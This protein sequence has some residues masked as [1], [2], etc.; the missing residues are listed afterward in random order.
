MHAC[1][2]R[3]GPGRRPR[4]GATPAG[5]ELA[6]EPRPP[7]PPSST[8]RSACSAVD[9][10]A[11]NAF[12]MLAAPAARR[13][14]SPASRCGCA[15]C[16]TR[17]S[18]L[19]GYRGVLGLHA[20]RGALAR[21]DRRRRRGRLPDAS[22]ARRIAP[23]RRR[24]ELAA[25]VT[26]M[27]DSLAQLDLIDAVVAPAK[28]EDDPGL[29][30]AR[31]VVAVRV[32]GHVGVRRSPVHDRGGRARS[33]AQHIVARPGFAL[34]GMMA[35]EAQIAG[36][37][38]R[39]AASRS[40]AAVDPLDADASIAELPSVGARRSRRCAQSPT[41]SSSTAAAPARSSRTHADASVTEIAAGSGLFGPHLF[42]GY[43][44]F[45]PAPAAAFAL[46]VVRRP[47]PDIATL[48]GGGWI[49]S[50]PP[51][52]DRLPQ[53]V[54]P[55]GLSMR[56]RE[57][58]GEVQTPRH[59]TRCRGPRGR[60]PGL[61]AAHQGRRAQRAP[62]RV[63]RRRRRRRRRHRADLPRRGEGVPVSSDRRP[64]GA[65]G[66]GR[67]PCAPA[68][69]ASDPR[70][71]ASRAARGRAPR[72]ATGCA[73]KAVGAGHSFTGIAAHR[74]RAA[75]PR[76]S[77]RRAR[78]RRRATARDPRR[79]HQPL[80]AARAARPPRPRAREH[81]RHRPADHR[82]GDLDRH[83]RH[84]CDASAASPPRSRALTLVTADRR[85]AARQRDRERR[86][87]ARR[88]ARTRRPRRRRRGDAAVRA[89]VRCCTRSSVPSR[90]TRCSTTASSAATSADHFEFYWFPH[91]DHRADQDQHPAARRRAPEA[92]RPVLA[93][94]RR[95]A[96]RERRLR[97]ALRRS[98]PRSR[99]RCPPINRLAEQVLGRSR[100]HRC[101]PRG[102][103]HEPR[104][105]GS[106]RW[107]TRCRG[108]RCPP[109]CARSDEL[110]DAQRLADLVPRRGARRRSRRHLAV[111]GI[112]SRHGLH[113]RAP[114]LPRGP[115]P[116]FRAV[117][118][119][120]RAHDGRPH[121]GKMHYRRP[122][123]SR[124]CTRVSTTS[125]RCATGSIPQGCSPTP[126]ST[127]FWELR[128]DVPVRGVR[129]SLITRAETSL[130]RGFRSN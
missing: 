125:S 44:H 85:A 123:N 13:S 17:C 77:R 6:G 64:C 68:R 20:R 75:R 114:L 27:V 88:R 95:R 10:L 106:A 1:D 25:R 53:L 89:G 107:S 39:P 103:R 102:V 83:P 118:A 126:T 62:Q 8:R 48:L 2:A 72:R 82:R 79:R 14:A 94:G 42:D 23:A 69:R 12:D 57:A 18:Q 29:P 34:V 45:T 109:R 46:S 76:R 35:Y 101:R 120:L 58:A 59:R 32:L 112:R 80:P 86:A 127:V 128:R 81:G 9:A 78:G 98:A 65:T 130:D 36:V 41:S 3:R 129:S 115:R 43:S 54:W 71:R 33:L 15:A 55:A 92:A 116:Y 16:S 99:A 87:A 111:D 61:A 97:D 21:R 90:S 73:V 105:C 38:D 91:T 7:R 30:R 19:P 113:R 122:R 22:T 124:R 28:R 84:G 100:L 121:W 60:R 51:A 63:R 50:G 56:P 47:A 74:G 66:R 11:H 108:T 5:A 110:I 119:I 4:R 96:R 117:E 67:S 52:P 104:A 37:G 93:L 26:I 24:R 49:A 31:R 70:R 40:T